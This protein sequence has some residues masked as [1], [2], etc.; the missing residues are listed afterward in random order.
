MAI[1]VRELSR[2]PHLRFSVVAGE[3]GLDHEVTWV[4]TSDL[5]DPWKWHGSGEFLLINSVGLPL[6]ETQQVQFVERLTEC[7]ASGL[8]IGLGLS[9][10]SLLEAA[11]RQADNLALPML[12]VPLS[13]PFT[14][15]VRAV[16]DA[17]TREESQQLW[18]VSRLYDL[19]RTSVATGRSGPEVFRRLG[20]E[21][22]VR[23]YVMDPATGHSLF[24]E[25]SG[26]GAALAAGFAAHGNALPAMLPLRLPDV[27]PGTVC[28]VAIAMPGE[29]PTALVV[30]PLGD[31]LPSPVLLQHVAVGG[32][33]ELAKLMDA[34]E[35][36]HRLG[37]DI[38]ARLM[39]R[40]M[41]SLQARAQLAELGLDLAA[42]VLLAVPGANGEGTML[43][44]R[45]ATSRISHL[46]L[47][48]DQIRYLLL[49]VSDVEAAL[50]LVASLTGIGISDPVVAPDRIPEAAQE[51]RWAL[52][53]AVGSDQR[54][55]RYDDESVTLPPRTPAE[56][57]VLVS[58]I[59]AP[60]IRHDD[61]Q[62]TEYVNTLR[63]VL[64]A[65]R[66]WRDA[67]AELHIHKQTLGYRIRKIEQ[68]TGR[69]ITR[70][71]HIAEW[72]LALRAH[73]L[74]ARLR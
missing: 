1:T 43:R 21:L 42:S 22:G 39:D 17:N 18:R 46:L 70:T 2:L 48:R 62:G 65:D 25:E 7:G 23:L 74:L 28:A 40:R 49:P 6:E 26:Y 13:T 66:S 9:G 14:T 52:A 29:Q 30:E 44:R 56:A 61:T 8:G 15:V 20:D 34:Q 45:L 69:G 51:A 38:L 10:P 12:T 5:P 71:D 16:A 64:R 68:I 37:S 55:V 35:R 53:V 50:T 67:A 63:V 36:Q 59:L 41:D 33:L 60:L 11:L 19:L 54:A 47:D 27:E 73:D 31:Q 58:R 57:T 24:A 72:W 3:A 4:H 32:A